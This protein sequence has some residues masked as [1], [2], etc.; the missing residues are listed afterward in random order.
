MKM[1]YEDTREMDEGE[2]LGCTVFVRGI[3]P[4]AASHDSVTS[5]PLQPDRWGAAVRAQR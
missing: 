2:E 5:C 4:A 3:E 1:A